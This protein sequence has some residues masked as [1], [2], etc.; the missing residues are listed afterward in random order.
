MNV[1]LN[2]MLESR[3]W[4]RVF[5]RSIFEM[6][7]AITLIMMIGII[8]LGCML[9]SVKGWIFKDTI[10]VCTRL[11]I[12][13][14]LFY[15]ALNYEFNASKSKNEIKSNRDILTFNTA[16]EWHKNHLMTYQRTILI[17]ERKF[18]QF[19]EKASPE[20]YMIFFEDIRNIDYKVALKG[21]LNHFETVS[22]G[23]FNGLID[24]AFMKLFYEAIFKAYFTKYYFFIKVT[25]TR[26][27]NEDIW[28]N[29]TKLAL[30]W[31]PELEMENSSLIN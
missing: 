21:I 24:K 26:K 22:I 17:F 4:L 20:E 18:L 19:H 30:D 5:V 6:R 14:S 8:I 28:V 11:F 9:I 15:T 25:R 3:E 13:I 27:S 31:T 16:A 10:E 23:V 12:V 29:F 1:D 2:S 7:H